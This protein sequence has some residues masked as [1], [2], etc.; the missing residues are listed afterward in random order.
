MWFEINVFAQIFQSTWTINI[1][2]LPVFFYVR[3][4][5]LIRLYE[6]LVKKKVFFFKGKKDN[7]NRSIGS[8]E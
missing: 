4:M 2:Y 5:S 6:W 8:E 3:Q 1:N 7:S